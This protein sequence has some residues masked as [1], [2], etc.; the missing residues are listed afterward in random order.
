MPA[1]H[2][3]VAFV[4]LA[5]AE[6][7]AEG[8]TEGEGVAVA[9]ALTA[10]AVPFHEWEAWHAHL[11]WFASVLLA[12]PWRSEGHASHTAEPATAEYSFGGHSVHVVFFALV[13]AAVVDEP[14]GHTLHEV[15]NLSV[16]RSWKVRP[17]THAVHVASCVALHAVA[18]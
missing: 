4:T 16:T 8:D 11:V 5:P 13:Q 14:A 18:T 9:F 10:H 2:A 1:V 3:T 17:A 12:P 6:G 7:K 15:Q